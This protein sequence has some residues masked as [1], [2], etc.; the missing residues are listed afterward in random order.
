MQ[1]GK[2]GKRHNTKKLF[3]TPRENTNMPKR[4]TNLNNF[5]EDVL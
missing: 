5:Q 2:E 4:E 3:L 1:E